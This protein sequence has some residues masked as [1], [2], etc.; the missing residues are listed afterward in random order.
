MLSQASDPASFTSM[1]FLGIGM[2][3]A[4][5]GLK[6]RQDPQALADH[7]SGSQYCVKSV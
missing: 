1:C 2:P 6:L 3:P 5:A 4:P 7:S